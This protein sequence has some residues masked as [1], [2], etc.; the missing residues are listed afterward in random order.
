MLIQID[1]DWVRKAR[2][3]REVKFDTFTGK[4]LEY[5]QARDE[6]GEAQDSGVAQAEMREV[7]VRQE[8]VL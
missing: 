2:F 7:S 1:T 6:E 8:L 5:L 3:S 4:G